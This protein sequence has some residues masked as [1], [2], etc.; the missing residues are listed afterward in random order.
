M[1]P[2]GPWAV[3]CA[4]LNVSFKSMKGIQTN[5]R[6][7]SRVAWCMKRMVSR[8]LMLPP[9][10][11]ICILKSP[12][13]QAMLLSTHIQYFVF[14]F[15]GSSNLGPLRGVSDIKRLGFACFKA[16]S[17]NVSVYIPYNIN[18]WYIL[19]ADRERT[20]GWEP[21]RSSGEALCL[22]KYTCVHVHVISMGSSSN[23]A[24]QMYL[25]LS[26]DFTAWRLSSHY[27]CMYHLV[28]WLL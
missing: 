25:H 18:C 3:G 5:S 20:M 1:S 27:E 26:L 8:N 7:Q 21:G 4:Q 2:L 11:Q 6:N 28:V 22:Q 23:T 14:S 12:S 9:S 16:S 13:H 17:C 10:L 24:V 19:H 15:L